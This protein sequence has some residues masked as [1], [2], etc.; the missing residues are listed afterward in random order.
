MN[1]KRC[2]SKIKVYSKLGRL[3][4]VMES[5]VADCARN[6]ILENKTLTRLNLLIY[7]LIAVTR[8]VDCDVEP[9]IRL[10]CSVK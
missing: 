10:R 3:R 6:D 2:Q 7:L 9:L 8:E 1:F 4:E 5:L